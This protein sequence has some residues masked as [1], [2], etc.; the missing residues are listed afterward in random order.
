[1][2]AVGTPTKTEV[3][4]VWSTT[5]EAKLLRVIVHSRKVGT[6]SLSERES[7]PACVTTMHLAVVS[8]MKDGKE[9]LV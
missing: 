2:G 9:R 4:F 5:G 6:M 1:M 3:R 8:V 7:I